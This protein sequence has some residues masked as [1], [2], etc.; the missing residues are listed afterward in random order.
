M[1]AIT[2]RRINDVLR[3]VYAGGEHVGWVTCIASGWIFTAADRRLTNRFPDGAEPMPTW[4]SALPAE[5]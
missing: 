3:E 1:T 5:G 2:T 4:E